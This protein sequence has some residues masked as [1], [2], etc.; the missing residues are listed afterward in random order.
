MRHFLHTKIKPNVLNRFQNYRICYYRNN[1]FIVLKKNV[2]RCDKYRFLNSRF[3][4]PKS[5]F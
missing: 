3:Q 4:I 1:R 2:F 5:R